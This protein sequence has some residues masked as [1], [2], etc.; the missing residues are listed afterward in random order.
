M[1]DRR[2][3]SLLELAVVLAIV[4]ILGGVIFLLVGHTRHGSESALERADF[5]VIEAG[6]EAYRG[7]FGDYPRN[8]NLPVW[9][10]E[11]DG[12]TPAPVFYSLAPALLGPGPAVTKPVDG[13]LE[14]GDGA[15]G[16]GF[17]ADVSVSISGSATAAIGVSS[18][19]MNVDAKDGEK[20]KELAAHFPAS[21][22][23]MLAATSAKP[24]PET[25]GIRSAV[26][27]GDTLKLELLAETSYPHEGK[28][29]ISAPSGKVWG[30]YISAERFKVAWVPSVDSFGTPFFGYGQPVLLDRWGQVIQY[31]PRYGK[32]SG[33]V[34]GESQ[35][36][37]VDPKY[38][39]GAS[40]DWRD[41]AP[42]FTVVGQTGPAQGWPNPAMGAANS[43]RPELAVEWMLEAGFEGPYF[44]ISVG[45]GGLER[46]NGGL[47][48]LADGGNGN[49][50]IAQS[51][52]ENIFSGCGNIYSFERR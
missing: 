50:P 16:A 6:L 35:P 37:S 28:C 21:A 39:Q 3:F 27:V 19:L 43:F 45:P 52:F 30:P 49:N 23:L 1:D 12:P 38:G 29:S 14:I 24:Y 47:C 2:G 18:V 4:A 34:F 41:G 20:A 26:I 40:F 44:L 5:A 15:E 8:I 17:R 46:P 32:G 42:F 25:I 48:N 9:K 33:P 11:Q 31:F 7:D 13:V 22:V 10:T 51:A 36:E